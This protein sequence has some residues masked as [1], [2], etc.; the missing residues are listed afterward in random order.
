[1]Y[2]ILQ[3]GI[4]GTEV[5]QLQTDLN[6]LGFSVNVDGTFSDATVAA[7]MEFQKQQNLTVDGIVGPQTGRALGATL[8]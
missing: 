2:Q 3:Q 7:V 4:T 5:E 8:R 1:M 6:R